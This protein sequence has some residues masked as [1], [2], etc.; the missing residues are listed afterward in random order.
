MLKT[1]VIVVVFSVI[2]GA[3]TNLS[4][5]QISE[6][7]I[8]DFSQVQSQLDTPL[9]ATIIQR[10]AVSGNE[11]I[12]PATI[13][14]YLSVRVGDFFDAEKID[15]SLKALY[16]TGLFAD[17][18]MEKNGNSLV[19]RVVESPILNR[20]VFEG[21]N[22][23]KLEDMFEEVQ[24][25]PRMVYTRAKVRADVQR[26]LELY[27]K[28]GYF[29]AIVEPK[30]IERDQ[31]RVDIVFEVTEGPKSRVSRINFIG[32]N[33]YSDID[34]RG[35]IAT[36]E[37]RWW[38]IFTSDDTYDPD[39]LDY[40]REVLRQF[41][42]AEGYADFRVIS[43]VAEL[44][45]DQKDFFLT[46]VVEE[47]EIYTF[48]ELKVESDIEELDSASFERMLLMRKG[49]IYNAK[50]IEDTIDYMTQAAG[51]RGFAFLD[52]RPRISRDKEARELNIT[53]HVLESPRTYVERITLN[54]NVRTLDKVIRREFRL[55]EGD[56]FNTLRVDR[57]ENRLNQL[58]F[59]RAVTIEREQGSA[60]DGVIL[61]V[62]VEE[63]ATGELSFGLGFSSL[64]SFILDFT[65]AE[66]NL[67]GKGQGLRLGVSWSGRRKQVDVS[68]TEPRFLGKNMQAGI[69]VF[70]RQI[71]SL[72]E[73]SFSNTSTG[74]SLNT[75]LP[76]SE[77]VSMGTRYTLRLDDVNIGGLAVSDFLLAS[78]GKQT[79]S[80]VGITLQYNSLNSFRYP[81]RG[82]RL[83][84]SEEF[85]GL[86]GN[87]KYIRTTV[88]YDF[89]KPIVGQWVFH[90][91]AE[92][93][94][95]RGLGQNVQ[96]NNRFFLGGPKF[97]G[98]R[99]AGV[100]PRD[101]RTGSFLGGNSFYVATVGVAIP[102]G[103]AV[104][105]M[106][107]RLDTFIDVGSLGT[108][109]L[110]EFDNDGNSIDNSSI[111]SNGAPRA[112]FGIGIGWESPF[113]PFRIDIARAIRKQEHDETEVIQFNV[114]TVF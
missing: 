76:L 93:G 33:I 97:R 90:A 77:Y 105:E 71:D 51:S 35:E 53:F 18:I 57:S 29:A 107:V 32:N 39:R 1:F 81:T 106:G 26:V 69:N 37:S 72:R 86:G 91:G 96:I 31:N 5:A 48:G 100:G 3:N 15:A 80:Q 20:I 56:A 78:E 21:N 34:L 50:T 2:W 13:A 4:L 82:Q 74:F 58:G 47:G 79:T 25:R 11:R 104:Q 43:A 108:I 8:L 52:V 60:P 42:L 19:I 67:L 61:N 84:L 59:F 46:M 16:A 36:K 113:G 65:I 24:L 30:Y 40:D 45:P 38:K 41:Y 83:T 66:R 95:I 7:P 111:F 94:H 89:Y 75:G 10:I 17:V 44:T 87:V 98:F 73:S 55:A 9:H 88:N 102:L 6:Q 103:R 54:G 62:N 114:G 101:L 23:I 14:S 92:Y 110:L 68:F 112:S 85:S 28:K 27:R 64:E 99:N 109:D 12:E 63:Q 22:K 70:R 49:D